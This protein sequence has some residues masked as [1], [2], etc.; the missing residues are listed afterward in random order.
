MV[1]LEKDQASVSG[2][3]AWSQILGDEKTTASG[4]EMNCACQFRNTN[5][6]GS[7]FHAETPNDTFWQLAQA[8]ATKI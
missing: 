7:N 4:H 1:N 2:I 6:P 3:I 8:T 5:T